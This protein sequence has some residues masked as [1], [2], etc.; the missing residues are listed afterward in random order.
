M[1]HVVELRHRQVGVA[2][3]RVVHGVPLGLLNVLGPGLVIGHRIDA[4]PDDLGVALVELGLEPG[5]V[6]ELGRA[7][8]REV[9]RM[10]EEDR[11]LVAD[12]LVETDL[13]FRGLSGEVG[14]FVSDAYGHVRPPSR[15][16]FK[17]DVTVQD[18][19]SS[20]A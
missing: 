10:G 8:G 6:A 19:D 17:L 9:L 3:D 16:C 4:E 15:W 1:N 18:G 5:H 14:G 7:H 2:D 12:P 20:T 13:S 11:P